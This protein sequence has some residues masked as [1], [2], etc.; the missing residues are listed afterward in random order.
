M[1]RVRLLAVAVAAAAVLSACGTSLAGSAARVGDSSVPDA[2]L[3][4]QVQEILVGTGQPADSPARDLVTATLRRLIT[5]DL[6]AQLAAANGVTVTRGEI[7]QQI[8]LAEQQTGGRDGLRQAFLDN[9]I[10]PSQITEYFTFQVQVNKLGPVLA[11]NA[12]AQEQS[13]AVFT[14]VLDLANSR[15]VEVSPRYGTW[16]A[17][18]LEVGPLPTD[19]AVPAET[20]APTPSQ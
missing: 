9:G 6:V 2:S 12:S 10:A 18:N 7:D 4:E 14:A 15:G 19:L 8:A 3:A 1:S 17:D 5:Q 20:P 11:P 13:Q 16:V